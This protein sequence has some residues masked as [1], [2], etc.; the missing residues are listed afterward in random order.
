MHDLD[1]VAARVIPHPFETDNPPPVPEY[2]DVC[3]KCGCV[4]ASY[5][6]QENRND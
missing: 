6:H 2:R 1:Q 5:I 4:R 3:S